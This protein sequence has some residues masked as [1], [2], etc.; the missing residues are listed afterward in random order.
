MFGRK[1]LYWGSNHFNGG[2]HVAGAG[3]AETTLMRTYNV[4]GAGF[5]ETTTYENL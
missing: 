1:D 3:F 2:Q 5:A 4:A